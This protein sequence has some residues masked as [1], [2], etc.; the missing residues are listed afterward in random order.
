MGVQP[1]PRGSDEISDLSSLSVVWLGNH[2]A[3]R[4][5]FGRVTA[6]HW[7]VIRYLKSSCQYCA[8]QVAKAVTMVSRTL[9]TR[10][11]PVARRKTEPLSS[12][13]EMEAIRIC[14]RQ[15]CVLKQAI[16]H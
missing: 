6:F 12:H 15:V 10:I 4:Q 16:N 5:G 2:H 14:D 11:K 3:T 7:L 8:I 13:G 1:L 9:D